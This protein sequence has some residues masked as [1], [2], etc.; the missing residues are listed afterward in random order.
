LAITVTFFSSVSEMSKYV[1]QTTADIKA[2]LGYHLKEIE[3]VRQRYDKAKKRYE[4]FKKITGG[5][6]DALKDTKQLEV[7]GFKVLVNPSA[8]YELT[9]M[10]E[11]ITSLQERLE[12]FE[13]TKELIPAVSEEN[14]KIGMVLNDGTPT[15]FMF[16]VQ[17]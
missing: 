3:G 10:E 6:S 12:A 2:A 7:A 9:I 11:A 5:K 14:M 8:E 1:D 17:D 15:G 13:K 16:Y 4:G